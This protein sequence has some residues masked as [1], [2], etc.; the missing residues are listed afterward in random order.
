MTGPTFIEDIAYRWDLER[1]CVRIGSRRGLGPANS[2][3]TEQIREAE[4]ALPGL[5][6]PRAAYVIL[7]HGE[8]NGHPIFEGAAKVALGLST[9]G[10]A[11][12]AEVERAF[13][14]GDPLRG[15]ILDAFGSDAVVQTFKH[16]ERRVIDEALRLGLWPGRRFCPGY[17]GWPLEEQRFLFSRV[18]AEAVGIRLTDSCM[19]IP[20]KSNSFRINFYADRSL[21]TRRLAP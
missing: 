15:L 5:L 3:T 2:A 18:D 7:D 9:V 11:L 16:V 8:T 14:E 21:T 6:R 17:K 13:R 1:I 19:M 20:R 12:E 4:K 10:P